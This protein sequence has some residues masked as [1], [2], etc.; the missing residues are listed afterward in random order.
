MIKFIF[1]C[2]FLPNLKFLLSAEAC[3]HYLQLKPINFA[4]L[5]KNILQLQL[6]RE[7][8]ELWNAYKFISQLLMAL[9][10]CFGEAEIEETFKAK[11]KTRPHKLCG[12]WICHI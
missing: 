12:F 9:T 1:C 4:I 5:N 8:V 11:L 10:S 3:V 2:P 6:K 7:H